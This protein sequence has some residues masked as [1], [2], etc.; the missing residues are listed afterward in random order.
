V[1]YFDKKLETLPLQQPTAVAPQCPLLYP[2]KSIL[3]NSGLHNP[4]RKIITIKLDTTLV[5]TSLLVNSECDG[6]AS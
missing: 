4:L 2:I 3:H 1:P 6:W 5:T